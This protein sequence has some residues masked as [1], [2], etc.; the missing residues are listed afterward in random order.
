[1]ALETA[2]RRFTIL[3]GF[4]QTG[5]GEPRKAHWLG[6]KRKQSTTPQQDQKQ[7]GQ[8]DRPPQ[9]P[10][11]RGYRDLASIT[12]GDVEEVYHHFRNQLVPAPVDGWIAKNY[13]CQL[14]LK[15][16]ADDRPPVI[17][18]RVKTVYPS[19]GHIN[20]VEEMEMYFPGRDAP[21][22]VLHLRDHDISL[23]KP[24][25]SYC[26]GVKFYVS[27]EEMADFSQSE[28]IFIER[29]F[30]PLYE[31]GSLEL[32]EVNE[33]NQSALPWMY[34]IGSGWFA[35]IPESLQPEIR[36][37]LRNL[38]RWDKAIFNYHPGRYS[39]QYRPLNEELEFQYGFTEHFLV[40]PQ[41]TEQALR[42]VEESF[43]EIFMRG[44]K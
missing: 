28:N 13:F 38:L 33:Q 15:R 17:L 7:G 5:N 34:V 35:S 21:P 43:G 1:M 23:Q 40:A 4:I 19:D 2:L 41:N 11:P 32:L 6:D 44:M 39:L 36:E 29:G 10:D 12:L 25:Q 31:T 22:D 37:H 24:A 16:I 18:G 30:A 8:Q 20:N 14:P 3:P 9:R 26:V 27:E 42:K